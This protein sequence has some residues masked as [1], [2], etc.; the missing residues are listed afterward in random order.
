MSG[1][2]TRHRSNNDLVN[3]LCR[4]S[5]V[6]DARLIEALKQVCITSTSLLFLL[7][8]RCGANLSRLIEP[9]LFPRD[10]MT[11]VPKR[12]VQAKQFLHLTCMCVPSTC[13]TY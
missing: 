12:L 5:L 4:Q 6:R 1:Y 2:I 8:V 3:D 7:S 9:I 11:I 13:L 10:L